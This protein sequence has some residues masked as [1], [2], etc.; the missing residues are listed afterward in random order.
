MLDEWSVPQYHGHPVCGCWAQCLGHIGLGVGTH[1][2]HRLFFAGLAWSPGT[3]QGLPPYTQ[4]QSLT[5]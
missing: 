5:I 1:P 3:G 2:G 4:G